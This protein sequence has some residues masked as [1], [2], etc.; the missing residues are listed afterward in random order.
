MCNIDGVSTAF[1][2][3]T[4]Q[5]YTKSSVYRFVCEALNRSTLTRTVDP[6]RQTL[7]PAHVW[8]C[9]A[10]ACTPQSETWG[11]CFHA[12]VLW[13]GSTW[14]TTSAQGAPEASLLF[15]SRESTIP[16]RYVKCLFVVYFI[17]QMANDG[18]FWCQ[19]LV[20]FLS[21]DVVNCYHLVF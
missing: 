12:T 6:S 10:W 15:T 18:L 17:G 8:G 13:Q 4:H 21:F 2:C 7:T 3:H 14:C 1:N 19:R 9:S 11:R 5:A 20:C 16:K